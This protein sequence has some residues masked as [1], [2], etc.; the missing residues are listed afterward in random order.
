[1]SHNVDCNTAM[2]GKTVK[3]IRGGK[4]YDTTML[5]IMTDGSAYGFHH[6]QACCEC[7]AI[8]DV[9]GDLADLLGSPLLQAE[10]T[11]STDRPEDVSPPEYEPESQTWTFYKFAT[12]NGGVTIRWFGESNG[13]YSES[14]TMT[15]FAPGV[16]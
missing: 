3:E 9:C 16:R 4:G 10:E 5:F 1:M 14:V 15:E 8:N 13:Y 11:S 12:I 6:D 2:V 7:V